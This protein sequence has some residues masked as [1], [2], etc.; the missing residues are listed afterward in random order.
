MDKGPVL[1][2]WFARQKAGPG[3]VC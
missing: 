3:S 1:E 2:V